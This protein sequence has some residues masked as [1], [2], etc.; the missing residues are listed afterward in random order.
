MEDKLHQPFRFSYIPGI[1]E[2]FFQ[3]KNT[4]YAGIALSGSGPTVI[5]LTK[6]GSEKTISRIMED[7]FLKAKIHCR[8]LVLETDLEGTREV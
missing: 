7:A 4:G 2:M 1:E 6:K 5:S 8:I 3:V